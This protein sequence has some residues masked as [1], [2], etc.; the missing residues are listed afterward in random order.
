[1]SAHRIPSLDAEEFRRLVIAGAA[2]LEAHADAIN[3]LNVFPVPDGDTGTNMLLTL[4]AA[5]EA[6]LPDPSSATVGSASAAIARAALL[7]A[8]GNSGV[9][10]SQYLRGLAGGLADCR[11]CGGE[12]LAGALRAAADAGYRAVGNPVEGTMLSVMRAAAEAALPVRG[13]P[14][15][16]LRAAYAAAERALARTPEQ[17]PV[18]EQAGVVDA[19]GQGVV[20]FLAGALGH[21]DGSRIELRITAPAGGLAGAASAVS[22]EFL[23]HTEEEMYGYCTQFIV[24]GEGLDADALRE[25]VME[26]AASTVVVGDDRVVRV[27]AHAD[28]PGPLLSMGAAAGALDQINVQNMDLQHRQFLV[29]HGYAA[30]EA[31]A[32]A[33]V[34]VAPGGGIE[35]LFDDLGAA[36]IVPGGQT[37]NPSAADI[38]AAVQRANAACTVVLPNN[39][40]VLLAAEQAANLSDAEVVVVPAATVPQGIAALLAYNPDRSGPENAAAMTKAIESVRSGEVT[41]AVRSTRVNGLDVTEGQAMAMLDGALVAACGTPTGALVQMLEVCSFGDEALVTLYY[42]ADVRRADAEAAAAEVA[43]RFPE[44]EIEV[45]EGGQP[46]YQYIV[47]VE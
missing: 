19:G 33:V 5:N 20:A 22:R 9:I 44:A 43:G 30:A 4:R 31:R 29:S 6:Q 8:R 25:R 10:F 32:F 34:A 23:E 15:D 16:V 24:Q 45:Y 41:I 13:T 1:M 27:H 14:A 39:A 28:D 12:A 36:A 18:L 35:R 2:C 38:L 46:H 17:L 26:M 21:L 3:A 42:G 11:E 47:S 37:M 40:N 7:G